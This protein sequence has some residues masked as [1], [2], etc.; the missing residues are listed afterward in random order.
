MPK[1][2]SF[3]KRPNFIYYYN[4]FNKQKYLKNQVN[5]FFTSS[6]SFCADTKYN[7]TGL[8]NPQLVSHMRLIAQFHAALKVEVPINNK[9]KNKW[10]VKFRHCHVGGV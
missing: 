3:S 10:D 8:A 9:H 1:F 4:T 6:F 2:Y 5:S 7:S